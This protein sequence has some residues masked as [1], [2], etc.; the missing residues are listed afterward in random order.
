VFSPIIT[1]ITIGI[2]LTALIAGIIYDAVIALTN[3]VT[4]SELIKK[5]AYSWPALPFFLSFLLGHFFFETGLNIPFW[6]TAVV[7]INLMGALQLLTVFIKLPKWSIAVI[8]I[9][10]Y[11]TG[12]FLFPLG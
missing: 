3:N 10:G 6:I 1:N 9:A 8:P 12:A 7:M 5:W 4:F 11:L 2:L